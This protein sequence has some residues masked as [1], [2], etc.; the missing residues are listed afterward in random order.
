MQSMESHEQKAHS[1]SVSCPFT[2]N[3]GQAT[4]VRSVGSASAPTLVSCSEYQTTRVHQPLTNRSCPA[5][6]QK[7]P[8]PGISSPGENIFLSLVIDS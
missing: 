4:L 2:H 6:R 3:A 8:S 7:C 1:C 5:S